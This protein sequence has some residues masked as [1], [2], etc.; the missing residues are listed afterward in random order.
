MA[1]R[2]KSTAQSSMDL[3]IIAANKG[4]KEAAWLEK[5][6]DDL[7]KR[8]RGSNPYIPTLYCDNLGGINLIKDTKFYNKAKHIEIYYFFI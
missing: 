5:V 6:T 1:Q 8:E 4:A 3:E 2:Q 7:G